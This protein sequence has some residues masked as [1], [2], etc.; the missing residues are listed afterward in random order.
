MDIPR[1]GAH[2]GRTSRIQEIGVNHDRKKPQ[3][4]R[5]YPMTKGPFCE[6]TSNTQLS[7]GLQYWGG[8]FERRLTTKYLTRQNPKP[9]KRKTRMNRALFTSAAAALLLG[10]SMISAPTVL[11]H[12]R[13]TPYHSHIHRIVSPTPDSLILNAS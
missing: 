3:R 4:R 12:H 11:A 10:G 7:F 6:S 1:T 9:K 8:K 5:R 2:G 13:L